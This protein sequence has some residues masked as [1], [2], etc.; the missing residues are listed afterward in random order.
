MLQF[1]FSHLWIAIAVILFVL[2]EFAFWY[3]AID[4]YKRRDNPDDI[5]GLILAHALAIGFVSFI[6]WIIMLPVAE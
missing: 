5:Q 6:Y 4:K 3:D 2:G 1:I